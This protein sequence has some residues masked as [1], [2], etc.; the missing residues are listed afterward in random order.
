MR[1]NYPFA[2]IVGQ[3]Q[4]KKALLLCAVNPSLGGVLV[5]GDKGTAKSTAARGLAEIL[6][7][8]ERIPGCAYNCAPGHALDHCAAC[9]V[10]DA[11]AMLAP[12]IDAVVGH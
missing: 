12:E 2:A 1:T 3:D 11:Q 9:Q 8:I 7:P 6:V 4:L 5:R 10:E